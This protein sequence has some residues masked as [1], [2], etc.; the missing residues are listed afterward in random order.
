MVEAGVAGGAARSALLDQHEQLTG[1]RT[2]R[3]LPRALLEHAEADGASVVVE[4]A[5]EVG[6]GEVH[7]PDGGL[8][9]DRV[10][11][12]TSV[13]TGRPRPGEQH[14]RAQRLQRGVG[15]LDQAS[16][17][18]V[19]VERDQQEHGHE[20]RPPASAEPSPQQRDVEREAAPGRRRR[21][22]A[23]DRQTALGT[24]LRELD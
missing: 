17:G 14:R 18:A 10:H 3:R 7:G 11:S 1:V 12:R 5:R 6:D 2:E 21:R 23:R 22:S 16:G 9:R 4:R 20:L 15:H 8:R 13:A 19:E 24:R